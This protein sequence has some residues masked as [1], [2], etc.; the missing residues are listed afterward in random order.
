MKEK[1]VDKQKEHDWI[2]D[3]IKKYESM[4]LKYAYNMTGRYDKAQDVVQ[5]TFLK[6]CN[7][8]RQKIE[9]YLKA[10]LFKVCRNR[11]LEIL[12]KEQKMQPL[13]DEYLDKK[14]A[15]TRS[16]YEETERSDSFSRAIA[17]IEGPPKKH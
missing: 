3:A 4:L 10:W 11:A 13:T 5:D 15:E 9:K 1:T 12:R 16:P 17:L 7:A 8:E 14:P 2:T 6:L